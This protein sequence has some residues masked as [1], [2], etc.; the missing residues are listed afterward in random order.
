MQ[1]KSHL[2]LIAT[3]CKAPAFR[4]RNAAWSHACIPHAGC[5]SHMP[6]VKQACKHKHASTSM[7]AST[8]MHQC[9]HPF[10]HKHADEKLPEPSLR[11]MTLRCGRKGCGKVRGLRRARL[12]RLRCLL[13]CGETQRAHERNRPDRL[14]VPRPRFVC[15]SNEPRGA[16]WRWM[17]RADDAGELGRPRTRGPAVGAGL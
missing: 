13:F 10:K 14:Y 1:P 2:R 5:R 4:P 6:P 8:T 15:A 3:T 12:P 7:H 17:Q 9:K 16:P 11:R